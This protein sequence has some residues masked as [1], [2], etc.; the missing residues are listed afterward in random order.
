MKHGG[1]EGCVLILDEVKNMKGVS[2]AWFA[3]NK[4]TDIIVEI[5]VESYERSQEITEA[6]KALSGVESVTL[7][8]AVE[9]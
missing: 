3:D 8:I 5:S 9:V 6:I 2:T 7:R 1:V 4:S